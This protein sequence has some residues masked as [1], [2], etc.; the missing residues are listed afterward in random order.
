MKS[1]KILTAFVIIAVTVSVVFCGIIIATDIQKGSSLS[2][3]YEP[4]EIKP[5]KLEKTSLEE[6]SEISISLSYANISILPSDGYYLEYRLDGTCTEPVYSVSDG[7]FQFQ[8]G[9]VQKKYMICFGISSHEP[10]FLNLY[11]PTD[12]YFDL[13]AISDESG[14]VTFEEI[15][16]KKAELVLDYGNLDLKT[17]TGDTVQFTMN[18]GNIK[19]GDISCKDLT[20][21]NDYGNIS[22]DNLSASK[23]ASIELSSGNFEVQQV[24]GDNLSLKN[25]YG[26]TSISSFAASDST[27]SIDSGNLFLKSADLKNIE[28]TNDYGNVDLE[29]CQGIEEYNYDLWCEYGSISVDK[30]KIHKNE[31]DESIYK[32]D[33]QKA[34]NIRISCDSGEV[35]ITEK[36]KNSYQ[37]PLTFNLSI[38]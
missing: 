33:N 36:R 32:K 34:Q 24:T 20:I 22:G 5:Y 23:S 35:T 2:V 21:N 10:F 29:L 3:S 6:F 37:F 31:D 11:V 15:Q 28:I 25:E 8:E 18:S 17:F 27:F 26:E 14:N 38:N 30:D 1:K 12:K 9:D 19:F 16:A 4:E 13:L 7:K